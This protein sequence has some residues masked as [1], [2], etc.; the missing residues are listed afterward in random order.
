MLFPDTTN[1]PHRHA[2]RKEHPMN[3]TTI[4]TGR[5]GRA[6]LAVLAAVL[7]ACLLALAGPAGAQAATIN[8]SPAAGSDANP[9]TAT[10]P[11]KTLTKALTKAK[12]GDTVKL[13]GGGYGTFQGFG[14]GETF[15]AGGLVVPSG[16][17]LEGATDFGFPVA[18][19]LGQ[20]SGIGLKLA[21]NATV[22]NLFVGGGGG[23]A[24]GLFAKQGT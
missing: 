2:Q 11:L 13:A 23:F 18:T 7:A 21:G 19:L 1:R 15:P 22:R 10:A 6:P 14:N 12:A 4:S 9:G 20:G 8:V 5:R 24:V 3:T 16:V 17:T